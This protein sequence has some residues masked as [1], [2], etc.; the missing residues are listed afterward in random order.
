MKKISGFTLL[1]LMI[2]ITIVGI[3]AS[4]AVPA[5]RDYTIRAK[6]SEAINMAAAAKF[7]VSEYFINEGE[8]PDNAAEAGL[9]NVSTHYLQ[10]LTY[11]KS[12]NQGRVILTLTNNV[13]GAA[14]GKKIMLSAS[15]SN[16]L[17]TWD[18][19]PAA[20]DG[21]AGKYLPSSCR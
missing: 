2:A 1:E 12:S 5:Y 15:I 10:S 17:L 14:N 19:Q 11:Q 8:L 21:L 4:L 3:L 9:S 13:G 18:C 16:D 7:S 20:Q 6:V